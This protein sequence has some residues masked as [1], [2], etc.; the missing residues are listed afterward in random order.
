[1][2]DAEIVDKLRQHGL[3]MEKLTEP[4]TF[5]VEVFTL[6]SFQSA[7][8]AFQG[9]HLNQVSGEYGTETREFPAGTIIIPTAQPLGRLA[10]YLL[11]PESDDGLLVWNFLDRYVVPQWSRELQTYPVYRMVKPMN[12]AKEVVR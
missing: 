2:P 12:L 6:R 7:E 3:V 4:A 5:E 10:S 1:V 11:E 8:R 9:H